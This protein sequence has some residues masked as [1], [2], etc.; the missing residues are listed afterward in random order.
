MN[1]AVMTRP[2]IGVKRGTSRGVVRLKPQFA[3]TAFFAC[4]AHRRSWDIVLIFRDNFL[5]P[6][7]YL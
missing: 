2:L 3:P 5:R 4:L 7:C 1:E 6:A